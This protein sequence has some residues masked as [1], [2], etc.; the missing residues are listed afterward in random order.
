MLNAIVY[1]IY[2]EQEVDRKYG[3]MLLGTL[4]PSD[5][6]ATCIDAHIKLGWDTTKFTKAT[7]ALDVADQGQDTNACSVRFSPMLATLTEWAGVNTSI[8][9]RRAFKIC[10]PHVPI[11]LFYDSVGVGSG[12]RAEAEEMLRDQVNY[13][14]RFIGWNGAAAVLDPDMN[15][16][17]SDPTSPLN[18]DF[19]ENLK[20][21]AWWSMRVRVEKTKKSVEA[22]INLY[23]IHDMISIPSHLI[24]RHKL[25]KELSQVVI[26]DSRNNKIMI[27]KTPQGTKSP[28]L[29]DC[30]VMNY[31]PCEISYTLE[32]L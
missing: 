8:T 32:N 17:L 20:A 16:I 1:Y 19:Y 2:F 31:F 29:A 26:K 5:W 7:G 11:E 24:N 15:T 28:N 23:P 9:A 13:R 21:Q 27:D 22:G 4:I 25:Q 10:R 18:K 12:V 14:V 30:I 3:A 6:V